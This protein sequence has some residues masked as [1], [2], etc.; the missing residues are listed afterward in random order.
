MQRSK[1]I[2]AGRT[3]KIGD[4]FAGRKCIN[5]RCRPFVSV[6]D[7]CALASLLPP[8][9]RLVNRTAESATRPRNP[10]QRRRAGRIAALCFRERSLGA[11]AAGTG[12]LIR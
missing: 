9:C 8:P 12:R 5:V 10:R 6:S 4:R 11:S 7:R 3:S 1:S 2:S